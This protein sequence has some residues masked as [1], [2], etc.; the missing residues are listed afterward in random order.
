MWYPIR[1]RRGNAL[2]RGIAN[3]AAVTVAVMKIMIRP[4]YVSRCR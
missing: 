3:I 2:L 4:G 1:D